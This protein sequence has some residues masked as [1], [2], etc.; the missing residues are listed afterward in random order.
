MT[1]ADGGFYE[2]LTSFPGA[3]IISVVYFRNIYL[4]SFPQTISPGLSSLPAFSPPSSRTFAVAGW[5]FRKAHVK[6]DVTVA[7]LGF[8]INN[9]ERWGRIQTLGNML[10]A[11]YIALWR[12]KLSN[13]CWCVLLSATMSYNRPECHVLATKT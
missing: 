7:S 8:A 3:E 1:A 13:V 12:L 4:L 6:S 9:P 11:L 10:E 5:H 2:L